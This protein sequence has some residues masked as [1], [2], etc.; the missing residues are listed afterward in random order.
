MM[1]FD[2]IEAVLRSKDNRDHVVPQKFGGI[3]AAF[4]A[5]ALPL[6]G[7]FAHSDGDLR[8]AQIGNGRWLDEGVRA[9]HSGHPPPGKSVV[10]ASSTLWKRWLAPRAER[11]PK[12]S[13][14]SCA[15]TDLRK[16]P[17]LAVAIC[18][19]I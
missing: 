7:D 5:P 11:M 14:A 16:P 6:G 1:M 10:T 2:H 13:S 9:L 15:L 3:L 17:S 4:A 18:S 8:R 12:R 19:G